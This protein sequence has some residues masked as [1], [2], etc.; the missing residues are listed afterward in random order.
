MATGALDSNGIWQYGEDDSNTTFS[1]L[2]NRLGSSVSTQIGNRKVLQ[3]VRATDT[4]NRSTTSTTFIDL[5]SV[6]ITP[7]TATSSIFLIANSGEISVYRTAIGDRRAYFQITDSANTQISGGAATIG[8][9]LSGSAD[10]G[11]LYSPINIDAWVASAGS[12]AARTYKLRGR[13][14]ASGTQ[15]DIRFDVTPGQLYAIEVAN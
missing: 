4:T 10:I 12:T 14:N 3:V 11:Q 5:I 9:V 7:K 1:A 13:A 6:S 8:S 15:L 2:L